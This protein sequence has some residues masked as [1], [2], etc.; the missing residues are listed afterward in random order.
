ML[1]ALWESDVVR[2]VFNAQVGGI[3]KSTDGT[4]TVPEALRPYMG[5]DVITAQ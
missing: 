3:I 1:K 4:I 2:L 5:C